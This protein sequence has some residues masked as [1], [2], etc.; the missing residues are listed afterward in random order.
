M[1]NLRRSLATTLVTL[2]VGTLAS[3]VSE[4]SAGGSPVGG[5]ITYQGQLRQNGQPYN[6]QVGTIS[7][8][9]FDGSGPGAASVGSPLVFANV[10]IADGYITVDLDFGALAFSGDDRWIE[11]TVDG[12][13]L[14]PRQ[15]IAAAPYA[16]FA[17]S[18]NE[19]P[20]GP[21]GPQGATGPA[22]PQGPQGATGATGPAGPAGAQGATG[23]QG[24]AGPQG[25]QGVAGP[26]GPAGS[27]SLWTINGSAMNYTG[28]NVSVGTALQQG[29]VT[30]YPAA[31]DGGTQV[32][33]YVR[34]T[35]LSQQ[36]IAGQFVSDSS[37]GTAL[38]ASALAASGPAR[39]VS[40][41]AASTTGVAVLGTA[42]A[43]SG[44]NYGVWGKTNSSSGFGGYFEGKGYFSSTTLI[45]R[46]NTIGAEIFGVRHPSTTSYGGMYVE[47]AGAAGLPFYGYAANG[48]ALGWTYMDGT[49]GKWHVNVS[50][51]RLTVD[52]AGN[53]GVGTTAP[54]ARLHVD[55]GSDA[56]P[57]GGGFIVAGATNGLNVV[58]D[59]NEIMARDNGG[60]AALSLNH[61][62]GEVRIGQGSGGT[63]RLV[64]PVLQITGGSDLAEGFDVAAVGDAQ[65]APGMLVSI[66]P[67]RPG[68][69]VLSTKAYDHTIAGII[70]G[71]NGIKTG[72]VMG[73][74]NTV[75]NGLHPVALTGRVY[76]FADTS[77]E[78]IEPGD[79]LTSSDIPGHA[80]KATDR[81]A[82]HGAV[83]GKAMTSLGRGEKGMVLVLVNLQ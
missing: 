68:K 64:T 2:T 67:A 39:G 83:I 22:G 28:G 20:V 71:A 4:A 37:N 18:G 51:N 41:T 43:A 79:L 23:P 5:A 15:R 24:P 31:G 73:Q 19:G 33:L 14:T 29:R 44:V 50:G 54:A 47:T 55:G 36:T 61:N 13:T 48:A 32:G 74:E 49:T 26:Q 76:V 63:G 56:G 69:L 10:P 34:N 30:I 38:S 7:F 35:D 52:T 8:Q 12:E 6:G 27:N 1:K 57:T 81:D 11:I 58:I 40:A 46:T 17:L 62:G 25:A 21:A 72:M 42:S 45:G 70:S 59:N 75:A 3:I 77:A 66:D 82:S 60:V 78:G 53:F 9:L 80:M 65:P 16:L